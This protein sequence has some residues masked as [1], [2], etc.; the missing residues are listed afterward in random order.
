MFRNAT[1]VKAVASLVVRYGEGPSFSRTVALICLAGTVAAAY[2]HKKAME[3]A[4]TAADL[5]SLILTCSLGGIAIIVILRRLLLFSFWPWRKFHPGAPLAAE[6]LIELPP[7][8]GRTS[9]YRFQLADSVHDLEAYVSESEYFLGESNPD[10]DRAERRRLY[11][12]W[13]EL[14]PKSFLFLKRVDRGS[15]VALSI[16]L[17]L[18][19]R[20]YQSLYGYTR[21]KKKVIDFDADEIAKRG[22]YRYLLVDTFIICI[23]LEGHWRSI[24]LRQAFAGTA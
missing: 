19:A 17:P 21:P 24:E 12:R 20:G 2:W 3:Q 16:I 23:A 1:C 9:P 10:L 14:S 5:F 6:H 7:E 13:H 11:E 15:S 22:P 18:S 4:A 8:P